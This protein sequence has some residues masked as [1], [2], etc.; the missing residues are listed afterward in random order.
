MSENH[1]GDLQPEIPEM[2]APKVTERVAAGM[3]G[4]PFL[5]I[6]FPVLFGGIALFAFGIVQ[7]KESGGALA[8]ALIGAGV[9]IA[10]AAFITMFGLTQVAPGEARVCQL[11]GRYQGTIRQDGLRW[12]NPFTSRRKISTRIRNH[13]TAVLKVNDSYGNPIE[14]AAVVVWQVRDSAQ[15]VFEVDDFVEFIAIQTDTAV[16][17]IATNYPYDAHDVE[18]LS[19][20]GNAEEITEKLSVE[21]AARVG[22]AGVK[23]IESRFTHLAYAPEI[24]SAMLQRQQAGAIVAARQ[25]IVEGAVGMVE[26]ALLRISEQG[27]VELDEERK[28]A[29]VSNLL[30]VLCGDRAAQPVLNTGTLYQ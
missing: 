28:A 6:A 9:V 14:L 13:E 16:R 18:G 23:I 7:A 2:P 10:L 5:L 30:V 15:A 26:S 20:R 17:H 21:I 24:A 12:V 11:F 22:A 27:I 25:T 3:P 19:L 29:M 4:L 8:G 1:T